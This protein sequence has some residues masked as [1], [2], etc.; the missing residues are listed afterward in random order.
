MSLESSFLF[1]HYEEAQLQKSAAAPWGIL[2][3]SL[4]CW[5]ANCLC[6]FFLFFW[7]LGWL[8]ENC[9]EIGLKYCVSLARAY[10]SHGGAWWCASGWTSPPATRITLRIPNPTPTW[11][12][13]RRPIR[14]RFVQSLALAL[15]FSS[16]FIF[17]EICDWVGESRFK[18][19]KLI[20]LKA[21]AAGNVLPI[22]VVI[23]NSRMWVLA[24]FCFVCVKD[25]KWFDS[26]LEF[27][28]FLY[29]FA[30]LYYA[31]IVKQTM[32]FIILIP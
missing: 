22:F 9:R 13:V 2:Y 23:F 16:H 30:P 28:S 5:N 1:S 12:Q 4:S 17:V 32:L 26:V 24:V 7:F 27:H 3:L 10:S 6:V 14:R 18:N 20:G 11:N 21:D 19:E 29:L 31:Y 8:M 25:F 15:S